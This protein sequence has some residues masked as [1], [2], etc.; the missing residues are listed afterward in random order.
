MDYNN[1]MPENMTEST[2][3][4]TSYLPYWTVVLRHVMFWLI[5]IIGI[6]GNCMIII[7]VAFSQKLHTS[8]NAFVT[9]LAVTDLFAC[10]APTVGFIVPF[11]PVTRRTVNKICQ[12]VGFV[13]YAS[14]AT[15]LYTLGAIGINRLILITKPAL[16]RRIFTSWK[17]GIFVAIPWILPSSCALIALLNGVGAVGFDSIY[18]ECGKVRTHERARDSDL[19]VMFAVGLPI[20]SV[21][22]IVSYTWIYLYIRKHFKTQKQNLTHLR[23][24][25]PTDFEAEMTVTNPRIKEITLQQIQITK[26][27][28]LVVCI[29]F[30]LFIPIG[31]ILVVGKSSPTVNDVTWYFEL[32]GFTNS[33]INVFIYGSKHPDFKIVLSHMMRCSYPSR[34]LKFLLSQKK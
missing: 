2:D 31:F 11:L 12:P 19:F 33:A 8:T 4:L 15:S 13:K 24:N 22:I 27:L 7:A 34:L 28:F 10:F 30:I 18:K 20:P 3:I 21:A 5:D 6:I 23:Q 26:N 14:I 32:V 25:L 17:L 9:S 16:Y 1:S 29:F